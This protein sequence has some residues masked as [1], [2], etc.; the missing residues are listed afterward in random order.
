MVSAQTTEVQPGD[1]R[2][3]GRVTV[4]VCSTGLARRIGFTLQLSSGKSVQLVEGMPLTAEELEGLEATETDGVVALV[5]S[6]PREPNRLLLRNRG[7][8]TWKVHRADGSQQTVKTGGSVELAAGLHVHFGKLH[9]TLAR[10][11]PEQVG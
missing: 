7:R 6:H 3:L 5:S 8:Q 2:T 4:T 1:Q 9:G 10:D 11:K